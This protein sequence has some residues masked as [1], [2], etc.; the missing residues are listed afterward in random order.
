M[1]RTAR[2]ETTH[3]PALDGIRTIAVGVVVA[4]H[5]GLGIF[6]NGGIGVDLFFVLSG[7]LITSLL[8]AEQR[9]AGNIRLRA[10][11]TR[12]ALRLT[13]ALFTLIAIMCLTAILFD[14]GRFFVPTRHFFASA[15]LAAGYLTNVAGNWF[16]VTVSD[17]PFFHTWSL[18][19]EEQFYLM[20]P[21]I[22]LT[23]LRRISLESIVRILA[24]AVIAM[25][26]WGAVAAHHPSSGLATFLMPAIRPIGLPV[27][28]LLAVLNRSRGTLK[29]P[30]W[31]GWSAVATFL[32]VAQSQPTAIAKA[33]G[34]LLFTALLGALIIAAAMTGGRFAAVLS[35]RPLVEIGKRSYGI[36][37]WHFP[38]F[39]FIAQDKFPRLS[40]PEL[41]VLKFVV[42]AG[43]VELS[44]R[45]VELPIL[46]LRR[47]FTP[48]REDAFG[49]PEDEESAT[50]SNGGSDPSSLDPQSGIVRNIS[51]AR[52]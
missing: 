41:G 36:Y 26:A 16:G 48:P 51:G 37:L 42:V 27:G 2:G 18:A 8:L 14:D 40:S 1:G 23:M 46:A 22:L 38:V 32:L 47:R 15:A 10:F 39:I 45:Y 30:S 4:N 43:L 19:T 34:L 6:K 29:V 3:L 13:P 11:Y 49:E 35:W 44:Y 24:V 52:Y 5:S 33:D 12:R 17:S 20:W 28:C 50:S 31:L 21:L 9:L 7:F 25:A